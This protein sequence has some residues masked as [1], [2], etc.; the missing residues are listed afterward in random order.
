MSEFSGI[1]KSF[2]AENALHIIFISMVISLLCIY[3]ILQDITHKKPVL[4][5]KITITN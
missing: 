1:T 3:I 2:L 5:K 4:K